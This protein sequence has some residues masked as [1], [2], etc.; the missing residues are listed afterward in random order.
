MVKFGPGVVPPYNPLPCV[1][2]LEH[3][4]HVFEVLVVQV[5]NFPVLVVLVKGDCKRVGD[6]ELKNK[7]K[8]M[9]NLKITQ[10]FEDD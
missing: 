8:L 1:D 5:P 3:G 7:D 6:V 10:Q 2:L 4:G 9:R